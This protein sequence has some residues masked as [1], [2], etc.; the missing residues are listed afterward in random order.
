ME[1]NVAQDIIL[2]KEKSFVC[3]SENYNSV[4]ISRVDDDHI[5]HPIEGNLLYDITITSNSSINS[6]SIKGQMYSIFEPSRNLLF[7]NISLISK[8]TLSELKD[9]DDEDVVFKIG[10]CAII[11]R[12]YYYYK[13]PQRVNRCFLNT[14]IT[15]LNCFKPKL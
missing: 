3:L 12:H 14:P 2:F 5:F 4:I 8:E 7:K 10:K 1:L 13:S 9:V 11:K 15:I 6:F